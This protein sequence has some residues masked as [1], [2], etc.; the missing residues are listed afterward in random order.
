MNANANLPPTEGQVLSPTHKENQPQKRSLT[1]ILELCLILLILAVGAY[2]R[3]VGYNWGEYSYMHPDE[4]FLIWVGSDISPVTT[5]VTADNQVK[6]VWIGIS[7]YFNTEISP[8]NPHNRGHGFYVYGTLPMFLTR[9]IVQLKYGHSGFQEMT[10]VGRFLS[11]ITDLLTVLFVYLAATRLYNR[12]VALL[13]AAFS[14]AAVMQIQQSHFFTMDTFINF[15]TFVAFYFAVRILVSKKLPISENEIKTEEETPSSDQWKK[16]FFTFI[17]HPFFYLSIGFGTALGMAVA[18][19]LSAVPVAATL[20]AAML[21]HFYSHSRQQR[22]RWFSPMLAYLILAAVVSLLVF[23]IGQPY[24]FSGPGFFGIKPNPLWLDNIRSLQAQ[25][26]G[27]VD[28]PPALQWADRPIWF[29]GQNLALWGLGLPLGILAT[30]GFLWMGWRILKGDWRE[31][32]LIWGWTAFFFSWQSMQFNPTMRYELPI[33]P[34]LAIMAGWVLVYLW[35]HRRNIV[36]ENTLAASK[37]IHSTIKRHWSK[38][39]AVILGI[40]VLG[41]TYAWAY[42]FSRIYVNPFTRVAASRWIYQNIP[43]PINLAIDTENGVTNQPVPYSY[44]FVI[45]PDKPFTTSFTANASGTLERI[46]LPHVIDQRVAR[47]QNNLEITVSTM[48]DTPL[49]IGMSLL[50]VN[51]STEPQDMVATLTLPVVLTRNQE[52]FIAISDATG[53]HEISLCHGLTLLVQTSSQLQQIPVPPL[54]SCVIGDGKVYKA[55]FI[56]TD[57]GRLVEISFNQA[58]EINPIE[59]AT[60]VLDVSITPLN[61]QSAPVTAHLESKL[62]PGKSGLGEGYELVFDQALTIKEGETYSLMIDLSADQANQMVRLQGTGIANEGDWDDGLPLRIQNYDGYGG[63]Y[64]GGL[65]FNMY[66]DDNPDK[67]LRFVKILDEA[68]YLLITS[69]RQWGTLPRLEARFP[70]STLYYRSLLGCPED[71]TIEWC[72][73]VV[74]PG[75]FQGSLGFE[76]VQVFQSNPSIGWLSIN[77]QFAEEAF[78]VYDHPK[79]FIFQK[80]AAYDPMQVRTILGSVDFSKVVRI[81]PKRAG[82]FPATLLLPEDRLEEQYA[83]GT[84]S[85]I[86]DPN[87][88]PNRYQALGVIVWYLA[89]GLLGVA[90]YPIFRLAFPGLPDHGYPLARTAGMLLLAYL[91][92]LGG[93]IGFPFTRTTITIAAGIILIISFLLA[94]VQRKELIQ[95]I[96]ER[97]NYFLLI[98]GL[99]LGFFLLFLLVRFGNPDL[100][101]PWKGGEKP[102]DFAY[103]N[104]VLKSTSFPPYDPW[105]EGGYLNYYY[106]GFVIVGVLIKWLGIIP[107]FA[108]NLFLPSL[109]SLVAIGVFSIVWNLTYRKRDSAEHIA[110]SDGVHAPRWRIPFVPLIAGISASIIMVILGNLASIKM[111]TRGLQI[112]ANPDFVDQDFGFITSLAAVFKGFNIFLGGASLPYSLGDWYWIPSR[113]MPPGDL[114]ITEFPAF[115]FLYADPHAHMYALVVATLALGWVLAVVLGR[116][117]WRN[118]GAFLLSII[119]GGIA[120]GAL[121]PTNT[122]DYPTYLALGVLAL[123]YT[124]WRYIPTLKGSQ[125]FYLRW[126]SGLPAF[127]QRLLLTSGSAILLIGLSILLYQPYLHWYGQ[128]YS[129]IEVW[130]GPVTPLNSYFTQWGLFLFVIF[131]WMVWETV[132]WMAETPLSALKKLIPYTELIVGLFLLLVIVIV[133]LAVKLPV[134]FFPE[135]EKLPFGKGAVISIIALPLAVWAGVLLLRPGLPD[136]KRLVLFLIGTG[137]VITQVVEVVVLKGDIGRQNTVFKLYLQVWTMF[138]I[139]AA[140]AFGWLIPAFRKWNFSWNLAWQMVFSVLVFVAA[141]FPILGGAAKIKDRMSIQAPHTLD[142]MAFMQYSQYEEMGTLMDLNQD[143][144][145]I[146]WIQDHVQ[147]SPVIVEANSG[148]LYRWYTRFSIYTGLPNVAGWEWHQQQQRSITPGEWVSNRLREIDAFYITSNTE[149]ARLFLDKYNVKYIILGQL[150]RATYPGS[151]LEKFTTYDGLFW[152]KVYEDQETVIYEVMGQ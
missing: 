108:Y 139:C 43:G 78:T 149:L 113:V 83:G 31:H 85:E 90:V 146:R 93:S 19:K 44:D 20:P 38:V 98:E 36:A 21:I 89:L 12:R 70:M 121:R 116:A 64:T 125:P 95:E 13:A 53:A 8:L 51:F 73:N 35:D 33:Y 131:S 50:P 106:Y 135:V 62:A 92:W 103:L 130:R 144:L 94:Y 7:E 27:D 118:L 28:F 126:L 57:D 67:L 117:R 65:N 69:S 109:F 132:T 122:W 42:A 11:A 16:K 99:A 100:W 63:I 3:L 129:S 134:E 114:A 30:T 110:Q 143:Y 123:V 77:D 10:N 5:I 25:S 151:G 48:Q 17:R 2:L 46:F 71:K 147:G 138:S 82:S 40:L 37:K 104:A 119:I 86:F 56:P 140:A 9:I 45:R 127:S 1:G 128:G 54:D 105:F 15:F 76:L 136:S 80:T 66:W 75:D 112:L 74:K 137:L 24:A 88:L 22:R 84:W 115:T 52:T 34:T 29:S 120:I 152:Q 41:S 141:L 142:G 87:S 96:R 32:A 4:R 68:E 81:T 61:G 101:H 47:G 97:R 124:L 79:V 14:A 55:S 102:M 150:E 145:A 91:V 59:L 6:D 18:S 111:I 23:R 60:K 26:S 72:Y 39:V 148:R 49:H 58:Y 107:A 133:L